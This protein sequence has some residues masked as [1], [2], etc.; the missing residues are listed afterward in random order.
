MQRIIDAEKSD[1]F[2]VLAYV[3]YTLPPLTREQRAGLAKAEIHSHYS[4][5]QEAF[6]DFVLAHYVA[7]GV[8]E[9]DPDKLGPLLRLKYNNSIADAIKDLGDAKEIRIWF[10]SFQRYLYAHAV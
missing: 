2:D 8:Q 9:L 3:A 4:A 7:E 5:K 1:L 6:L 10:E